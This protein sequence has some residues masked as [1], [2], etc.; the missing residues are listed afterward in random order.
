MLLLALT[1]FLVGAVM[2]EVANDPIPIGNCYA[3]PDGANRARI[4]RRLS[5]KLESL[6]V[7]F[8]IY[9]RVDP[10]LNFLSK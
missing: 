5:E 1:V 8:N 6:A 9:A 7:L 3:P 2:L 4:V 10:Y